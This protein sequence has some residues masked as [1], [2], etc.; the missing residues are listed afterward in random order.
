MNSESVLSSKS[1]TAGDSLQAC[2][3]L[4]SD[5]LREAK[6]VTDYVR[7]NGFHYGDAPVN[8]AFNCDA[9]LVSCDRLV[10]W[11]MYRVGF[12]DQVERQGM[13][14]YHATEKR[15]DLPGW[16]EL[17]GFQKITDISELQPG[18][19]V[20]VRPCT[21]SSGVIYPGHTFIF[22]GFADDGV[23]SYRYDCGKIERIQ[24][25]QPSCEPLND[26][27]FAYRPR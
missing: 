21:S 18:D 9:K 19:I 14:V 22:A 1:E 8:P 13:V 20:F 2:T 25:V 23:N 10:D 7:E 12:T 4:Q 24:S 5:I 17:Q 27:M 3:K 15:R 16:C 26:F 11:V 6:W